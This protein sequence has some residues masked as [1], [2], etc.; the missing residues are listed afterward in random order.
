VLLVSA[1]TTTKY[2]DKADAQTRILFGDGAAALLLRAA[3]SGGTRVLAHAY[4]S[5]GAGARFFHLGPDSECG[6]DT[7]VQ[8]DGRALFRFAVEQGHCLLSRLCADAGVTPGDIGRVIVH[9]A[10]YRIIEALQQ[11]SGIPADRWTV[12]IGR[13]GNVA[14]ASMPL[15]LVDALENNELSDGDLVLCAGFGAGLTWAGM[16]VEW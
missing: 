4:G 15:A 10:N 16:L 5:D 14:A 2:L 1:D 13:V 6:K 12:N 9:Q 7:V 11:R 3:T 8:M